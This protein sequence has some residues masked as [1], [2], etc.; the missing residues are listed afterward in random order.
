M[1]TK[2]PANLNWLADEWEDVIASAVCSGIV[3]DSAHQQNPSKHNSYQDNMNNSGSSWATSH[4][5][6]KSG[7]RD[8]ACAL[9]MS[10]SSADMAK[11]HGRFKTLYNNRKSDARA[12]Y[13]DCFNGDDSTS[14]P[15]RYDLPAGSVSGTDSSHEWH[16]HVETFYCYVGT[17]DTSD[18]AVRAILSVVKGETEDQWAGGGGPPMSE[19]SYATAVWQ[20]KAS[21]YVD[22]NGNGVR[23][24]RAPKDILYATHNFA[25]Q[26]ANSAVALTAVVESLAETIRN[27]GGDVDTQAILSG[28]EERLNA[29]REEL[30]A[31]F[32][33]AFTDDEAPAPA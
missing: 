27:G 25:Y 24:V 8:M 5:K 16:E 19:E 12:A 33:D 1:V 13:V 4:S 31:R 6:D 11:V 7:P 10:M 18:A 26:A 9:D 32:R 15:K 30:E 17:D 2:A 20:Q 28:V 14:G 29:A 3:G 21:E 22:E 23:D